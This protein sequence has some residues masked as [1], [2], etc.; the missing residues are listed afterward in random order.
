MRSDT[1]VNSASKLLEMIQEL[2]K[3][4]SEDRYLIVSV[5][6]G[7]IRSGQQRKAIEVYCR[8][9]AQALNDKGL[10]QRAVMAKMKEGVDLPWSQATVKDNLFRPIMTALI[11]KQSTTE[12]ER[13]EVTRVYDALNRWTSA[14]FGVSVLF[15]SEENNGN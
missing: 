8:E 11:K 7:K 1:V 15:P 10:D 5:E 2:Q 9:L 14:T 12:L 4:F 6:S 3:R 13:D